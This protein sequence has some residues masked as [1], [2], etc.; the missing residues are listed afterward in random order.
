MFV[1][2]CLVDPQQKKK[3]LFA[4]SSREKFSQTCTYL[5][6]AQP[7]GVIKIHNNAKQALRML[8]INIGIDM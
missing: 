8:I 6:A 7:N 5:K 4:T 3:Y 2:C 1:S